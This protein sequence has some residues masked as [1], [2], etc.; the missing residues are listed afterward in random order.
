MATS[1]DVPIYTTTLSTAAA[2]ITIPLTDYQQYRNLK[3]VATANHD[4]SG[5]GVNQWRMQFNGDSTSGLYSDT[6]LYGNGSNGLSNRDSN[7]NFIYCGLVGQTSL[8]YAPLTSFNIM[9]YSNGSIHKTVIVRGDAAGAATYSTVGTWRNTNA[10]TSVTLFMSGQNL[11]AGTTISVYGI[12]SANA[13]TKATG[14]AIYSDANYMYHVFTSTGA[15]TPTQSLT[16]DVLV[17]AGGGGGGSQRGCRGNGGGGAGGYRLTTDSFTG[18]TSYTVTVGAGGAAGTTTGSNGGNSVINSITSVGGGGGGAG[19]NN[20]NAGGSG[21]GGVNYG[22]GGAASPSG[23]GNA[24]GAGAEG[25]GGGG[26]AGAIGIAGNVTAGGSGGNGGAGSNSALAWTLVTGTGVNGYFAGG[27]GGGSGNGSGSSS[28]IQGIGGLG[29]GG[30]ARYAGSGQ[31]DN[32]VANTG[33]GGAGGT[34]Y[35]GCASGNG[36][37]GGSGIVIV[38]YAR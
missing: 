32:G 3:I 27:G 4:G 31:G 10:I 17:V 28:L 9:N 29:G 15:F 6:N 5:S 38:R 11:K 1:T 16:A 2:N 13:S 34:E 30:T 19:T 12:G 37:T 36:G 14:G 33:G 22:T 21:G 18:S 23:Q 35:S 24:G 25:G 7:Q 26:G 20:G 8:T